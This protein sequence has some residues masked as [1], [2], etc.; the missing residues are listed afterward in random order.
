MLN[1]YRSIFSRYERNGLGL[2][3]VLIVGEGSYIGQA[4]VKYANTALFSVTTVGARNNRWKSADFSKF[5]TVIHCAGIAHTAQKKGTESL[6][7]KVN[8]DLSVSVAKAAKHAGVGQFIYLSSVAAI[9]PKPTNF[10]GSSKLKAEKLLQK[11][12]GQMSVCIVR[13]PM[14]YG[15]GCKG[16]FSKFVKLVKILPVYPN[17]QNRR[18]M[19][20]IDN[21]CEFIYQAVLKNKSGIHLPQNAEYVDTTELALLV[22]KY[23]NRKIY[24]TKVFNPIIYLLRKHFAPF[25]K[26]FGDLAFEMKGDESDYNIVDFE[27]FSK[28]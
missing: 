17:V 25:N 4:L 14:V 9:N 23:H 5:D 7:Y 10:Y 1:L 20:S 28:L 16:N 6:Y 3:N 12:G 26:L 8:C 11:L 21:L 27:S 15:F 2:K 13:P 22:A 24:T 18:S 19:I